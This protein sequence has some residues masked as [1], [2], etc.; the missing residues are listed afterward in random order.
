VP[1]QQ[2]IPLDRATPALPE[3]A[4]QSIIHRIERTFS[5]R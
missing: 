2:A 1:L 3:P 5:S 4:L